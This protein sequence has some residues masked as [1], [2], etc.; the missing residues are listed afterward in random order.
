VDEF[1]ASFRWSL[2]E[3]ISE[4]ILLFL[5]TFLWASVLRLLCFVFL[6]LISVHR[7]VSE[8][9]DEGPE[10]PLPILDRAEA[11]TPRAPK[12]S[13]YSCRHCTCWF[14]CPARGGLGRD[15][16]KLSANL[17]RRNSLSAFDIDVQSGFRSY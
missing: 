7:A 3:D 17:A 8:D 14:A 11:P 12:G 2:Y 5:Y 15:C 13:G 9:D 10:C 4:R 16:G 6:R 1:L